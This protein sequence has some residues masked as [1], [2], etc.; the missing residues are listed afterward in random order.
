MS[1]QFSSQWQATIVF[2]GN[3]THDCALPS[4]RFNNTSPH[5]SSWLDASFRPRR[6]IAF[7]ASWTGLP[8]R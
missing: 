8:G 6:A 3:Y 4:V 7:T 1:L 5:L 2:N